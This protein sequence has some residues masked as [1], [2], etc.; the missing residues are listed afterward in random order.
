[1]LKRRQNSST[2]KQFQN[3]WSKYWQ[4]M[5]KMYKS[6]IIGWDFS[7]LL[8][9]RQVKWANISGKLC[10]IWT[11]QSHKLDLQDIY[12][13]RKQASHLKSLTFLLLYTHMLTSTDRRT[14]HSL[15][16]MRGLS[17]VPKIN[18][19]AIPYPPA[20]SIPFSII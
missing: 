8:A 13:H 15:F 10:K 12:L 17:V 4:V 9:V 11:T 7:K 3:I 5:K 2:S 16:Y 1:M 6:I 14:L 20:P 18:S 19:P